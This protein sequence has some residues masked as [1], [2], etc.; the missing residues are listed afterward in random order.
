M[1]Q[2]DHD[3]HPPWETSNHVLTREALVHPMTSRFSAVQSGHINL[4][5][6][7]LYI[8]TDSVC[9]EWFLII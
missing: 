8:S 1:N 6:K 5:H 2:Y 4:E 7:P 9:F 3:D